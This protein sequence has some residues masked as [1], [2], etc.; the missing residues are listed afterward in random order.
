MFLTKTDGTFF[1]AACF[2]AW[3]HSL[4]WENA[5]HKL[6]WALNLKMPV[7]EV[8]AEIKKLPLISTKTVN[9]TTYN[10][11]PIIVFEGTYPT[12]A[13]LLIEGSL[14]RLLADT[15]YEENDGYEYQ[16]F[17]RKQI[18]EKKIKKLKDIPG[19]LDYIN[20]INNAGHSPFTYIDIHKLDEKFTLRDYV[21]ATAFV[22]GIYDVCKLTKKVML[23]R[24]KNRK[25]AGKPV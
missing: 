17:L 18:F 15:K 5:P 3:K 7:E 1:K 14:I 19:N 11:V 25:P 21:R 22:K 16:V 6:K 13:N 10:N 8:E 23:E 2:A 4:N 24:A 12:F 9:Q 20:S